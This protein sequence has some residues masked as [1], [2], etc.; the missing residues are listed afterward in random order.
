MVHFKGD[1]RTL[2]EDCRRFVDALPIE[3]KARPE[4]D[5]MFHSRVPEQIHFEHGTIVCLVNLSVSLSSASFSHILSTYT[6][7]H[8]VIGT[9]PRLPRLVHRG[10]FGT[11]SDW[12]VHVKNKS[13][14]VAS[15][16]SA[17]IPP[18][19][20]KFPRVPITSAATYFVEF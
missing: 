13:K 15:R 10:R 5:L 11:G 4:R 19:R 8:R 16:C 6:T 17:M 1:Q 20:A 9:S 2:Y 3:D 14:R 12:N 7:N 18:C